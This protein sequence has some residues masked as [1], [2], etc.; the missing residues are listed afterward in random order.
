MIVSGGGLV[1]G[2][3]HSLHCHRQN[4]EATENARQRAAEEKRARSQGCAAL[5]R[6]VWCMCWL[7]CRLL[8]GD[9][10]AVARCQ[11]GGGRGAGQRLPH[12]QELQLQLP[13]PSPGLAAAR[14][15][16]HVRRERRGW[17]ART[18]RRWAGPGQLVRRPND[19]SLPDPRAQP[20]PRAVAACSG[21]G[22]KPRTHKHRDGGKDQRDY[23]PFIST[24]T[25]RK[26][27][28]GAGRLLSTAPTN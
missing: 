3:A 20:R 1:R 26:A 11:G 8:M 28:G 21:R 4:I 23:H 6:S 19:G 13:R 9:G 12:P 15:L 17:R 2:V 22:Q 25:I 27:L 10:L 18:R 7:P 24:R 14:G 5:C 16:H